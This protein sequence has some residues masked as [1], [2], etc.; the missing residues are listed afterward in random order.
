MVAAI[1]EI[2][3]TT[4]DFILVTAHS[5]AACDEICTRLVDVLHAGELFRLYAKSFNED[6]V[7]AKIKPFCN[8]YN[9]E[10]QFPSLAHLYQ[11]RVV[12]STL[13]TAGML[14]RAREADSDFDSG[15]FSRLFIDEAGCVHEPVSMIPIAG[16]F[17]FF[18]TPESHLFQKIYT[19]S[20]L[21][22]F[23]LFSL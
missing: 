11:F 21:F 23:Y 9:G 5:N 8:L 15:H 12:V 4:D 17:L 1:A 2:V 20:S 7:N 10:F 13:L 6:N 16:L 18:F 19:F 22:I 14:S 3:R